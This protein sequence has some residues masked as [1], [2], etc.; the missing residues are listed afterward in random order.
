MLGSWL[1][2][3]GSRRT[4]KEALEAWLRRRAAHAGQVV[5][6]E[7]ALLAGRFGRYALRRLTAFALAR[8][9]GI[10]LHVVELTWLASVFSA[11]PFIASLALQNVTLVIDALF[12]GALE[13]MR[14]RLRELGPSTEGAAIVTRWL[15]VSMWLAVAALFLPLGRLVWQWGEDQVAPSLFHVYAIVCVVRLAADLVIRTYYSGVFAFFRVYRPLWTPL[16]P[17]TVVVV[18]T[19]VLWSRL[20]GWAFPVALLAAVVVSRALLFVYTRRAYRLRRVPRPRVRPWLRWRSRDATPWR[21]LRDAALAGLANTSTRLGG[22]VLLAAIVPSLARADVFEE[23]GGAVEPFAFALHL[24]APLLFLA[25]QWGLV[26]YHDWKRLED[27][28]AE[29]LAAHLHRRLLLT[30]AV[31]GVVTWASAVGLI[32][33][34]IPLEESAFT[35]AA[36]LPGMLGLSLWTAL[37]LRGFARGEFK[38]QLASALAMLL[39][40]WLALSA[41]MLG[42]ATWYLALGLGPWVAI[43]LHAVLARFRSPR[44][45]GEL[46]SVEAWVEAL[47][48]SRSPVRVWQARSVLRPA[49]V[50]VRI[51]EA[52]G[53]RGALVRSGA[54]LLWYERGERAGGEGAGGARDRAAWLRHASGALTEL[55]GSDPAPGAEQV[56]RLASEGRLVGPSEVRLEELRAAHAGIF[57]E[58]IVLEVG[59]PAPPAFLVLT[60]AERQAIWRDAMRFQRQG[61]S[62]SGW[63]VTVVGVREAGGAGREVLFAARRPVTSEQARGWYA[64]LAPCAWRVSAAG[65]GKPGTRSVDDAEAGRGGAT[66]ASG[67]RGGRGRRDEMADDLADG[68]D[69]IV[70]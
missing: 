1:S 51:A 9:W 47:R 42:T 63:F 34:W 62:R 6:V 33:L 32:S 66:E 68:D 8:G 4:G 17:P 61:R 37:Q 30:A 69:A 7:E 3:L 24:A 5:A 15:T 57:P 46:H 53:E 20:A 39:V 70:G 36:L 25:S 49:R 54:R 28:V 22:L 43:A 18:G 16:V 35:L 40:V 64:A 58:G 56:E 67:G 44:A 13:G 2:S 29:A 55:R 52:L 65:V 26:F 14:R 21:Q 48:A 59:G 11:K 10:A 19:V 45:H 31:I 38:R 60:P 41:T 27:D 12:F 23:E 50:G